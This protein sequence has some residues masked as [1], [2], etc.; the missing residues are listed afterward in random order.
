MKISRFQFNHLFLLSVAVLIFSFSQNIRA[1][2]TA[3]TTPQS[4]IK[5][6][7]NFELNIIEKRVTEENYQRS[8]NVKLETDKVRVGVGASVGAQK[9]TILMRGI[10]GNVTFRASLEP[11]QQ[12]IDA[13][14]K[15]LQPQQ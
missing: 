14:R 13:L 3:P 9:I 12:R 10:K 8:T 1:Q 4:D 2:Q 15:R 5:K 7:E 11:V 6:E